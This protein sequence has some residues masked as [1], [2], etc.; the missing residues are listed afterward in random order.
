MTV[1]EPLAEAEPRQSSTSLVQL[2]SALLVV[3]ALLLVTFVRYGQ[4]FEASISAG[5]IN[6]LQISTAYVVD[7][8]VIFLPGQRYAGY[9]V[10]AGCTATL[11]VVPFFLVTAGLLSFS[12]FSLR[13]SLTAL[14]V[15][16]LLIYV[17]NQAR[18]LLIAG[19]M[20]AFGGERGYELSHVFL[21]TIVSTLG[22]LFA[23]VAF[24]AIL[25]GWRPAGTRRHRPPPAELSPVG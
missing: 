15:V 7:T 21:G 25:V 8:S 16:T 5:L 13:R 10:S 11:L 17:A 22:V 23:I 19:V 9:T 24:V 4:T 6:A 3:G 12:R 2:T 1:T 14:S 20:R 18:L